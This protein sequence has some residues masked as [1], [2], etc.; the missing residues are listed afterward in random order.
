MVNCTQVVRNLHLSEQ[1]N[2]RR[3]ALLKRNILGRSGGKNLT[4]CIL[5][6]SKIKL[7]IA[8]R[9][10]LSRIF[11]GKGSQIDKWKR[12]LGSRSLFRTVLVATEISNCVSISS[13]LLG[14]VIIYLSAR[15]LLLVS[16][17]DCLMIGQ[18]LWSRRTRGK[19]GH[20]RREQLS[21]FEN[22]L[23]GRN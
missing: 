2:C 16:S 3:R 4:D 7:R 9:G 21:S 18:F 15:D 23:S 17:D 1:K 6:P 11:R 22:L 20:C 8:G 12:I 5:K 13:T 10:K 19:Q 14:D